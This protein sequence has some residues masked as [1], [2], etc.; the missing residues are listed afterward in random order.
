MITKHLLKLVFCPI[1]KL[2]D[3]NLTSGVLWMSSDFLEVILEDCLSE[4]ELLSGRIRSIVLCDEIE[5]EVVVVKVG[6]NVEHLRARF[7][8]VGVVDGTDGSKA[9]NSSLFVHF[10]FFLL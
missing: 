7:R 3:A 2:V 9:S 10:Y 4:F 5:E 8:G 6:I 1:S